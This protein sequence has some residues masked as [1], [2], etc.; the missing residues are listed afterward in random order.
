MAN[1]VGNLTSKQLKNGKKPG[2]ISG[3][4]AND[5]KYFI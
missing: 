2:K 4:K 5:K 1:D 3:R